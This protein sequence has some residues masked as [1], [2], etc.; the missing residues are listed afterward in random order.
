MTGHKW[1]PAGD[2]LH[3]DGMEDSTAL[4]T[5]WTVQ[6]L[7]QYLGTGTRYV[8]RLTS[9]HRIRSVRVGRTVRFRP[10]DVAAWLDAQ[11]R[12][13]VEPKRQGRPRRVA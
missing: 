7:A 13:R 2:S 1:H 8:Y 9:E 6:E 5:L 4:P 12:N 10:E 11:T 3:R